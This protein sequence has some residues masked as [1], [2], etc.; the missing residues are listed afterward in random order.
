MQILSR[1]VKA[2]KKEERRAVAAAKSLK[3]DNVAK[4]VVRVNRCVKIVTCNL[5]K[6]GIMSAGCP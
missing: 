3:C 5:S 6:G 2:S 1:C 4:S